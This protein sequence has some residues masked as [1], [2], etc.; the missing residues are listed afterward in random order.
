MQFKRLPQITAVVTARAFEFRAV[1]TARVPDSKAVVTACDGLLSRSSETELSWRMQ[2]VAKHLR[3]PS[4]ERTQGSLHTTRQTSSCYLMTIHSLV[5]FHP[6]RVLASTLH[7]SSRLPLQ[8]SNPGC[9]KYHMQAVVA[10]EL[11]GC[12]RW[13]RCTQ[14]EIVMGTCTPEPHERLSPLGSMYA[15]VEIL[16]DG[17]L[18]A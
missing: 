12:H 2:M 7:L 9:Q 6:T 13:A 5:L 10:T 3:K 4:T 15:Y 18:H 16:H 1:V 11:S 8:C 17:H 14:Q